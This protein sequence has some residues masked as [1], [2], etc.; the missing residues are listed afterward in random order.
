MRLSV[1]AR[2]QALARAAMELIPASVMAEL[3]DRMV[4]PFQM[5]LFPWG[6]SANSQL[7]AF[8]LESVEESESKLDWIFRQRA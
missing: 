8:L 5:K 7:R 2:E 3:L 6:R 1:R 4:F